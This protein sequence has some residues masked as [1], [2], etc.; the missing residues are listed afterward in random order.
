MTEFR[1]DDGGQDDF[2]EESKEEIDLVDQQQVIDRAGIGDNDRHLLESEPFE[3]GCIPVCVSRR[4]L[5][6]DIVGFEESI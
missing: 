1:A 2:V 5:D 6:P 4:I 3:H